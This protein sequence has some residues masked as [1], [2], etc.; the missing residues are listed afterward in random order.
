MALSVLVFLSPFIESFFDIGFNGLVPWGDHYLK[1]TI[2]T[3]A[4]FQ[5]FL[6]SLLFLLTCIGFRVHKTVWFLSLTIVL[7]VLIIFIMIL[8]H[9][10]FSIAERLM[11]VGPELILLL[12]IFFLRK[13]QKT[14][15]IIAVLLSSI[16]L[17]GAFG[18]LGV[19]LRD[20]L[21]LHKYVYVKWKK[22]G[23]PHEYVL[24][25]YDPSY[26]NPNF[27][28]TDEIMGI[29]IA[30]DEIDMPNEKGWFNVSN[31]TWLAYNE[32]GEIINEYEVRDHQVLGWPDGLDDHLADENPFEDKLGLQESSE[33]TKNWPGGPEALTPAI[34]R[35]FYATLFSENNSTI[36]EENDGI[37]IGDQ[38]FYTSYY[39]AYG[40]LTSLWL[41]ET[42][43][44]FFNKCA[45]STKDMN[46]DAQSLAE[47]FVGMPLVDQQLKDSLGVDFNCYNKEAVSWLFANMVP[48]PGSELTG[49]SFQQLYDALARRH[50][51]LMLAS[52]LKLKKR[53]LLIEVKR[54]N[55]QVVRQ[56]YDARTY[57]NEHY[58]GVLPEFELEGDV[59]EY[60]YLSP[61][62]AIGYW[63]RRLIDGSANT[64]LMGYEH[65]LREY[66]NSWYLE[67]REEHRLHLD[68]FRQS[69]YL[70]AAEIINYGRRTEQAYEPED[71][72][73]L[74]GSIISIEYGDEEIEPV[75]GDAIKSR[76]E[77]WYPGKWVRIPEI[78]V[79]DSYYYFPS[80][81]KA[82]DLRFFTYIVI[83][84]YSEY[85]FA[86]VYHGQYIYEEPV[87]LY[88][89]KEIPD[90]DE[91]IT[92]TSSIK[93]FEDGDVEIHSLQKVNGMLKEEFKHIIGKD[94]VFESY[95]QLY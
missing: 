94:E 80:L 72:T 6:A 47:A 76:M 85:Q 25:F 59:Y 54:F 58:D 29:M 86:V 87:L 56:G 17:V 46:P 90:T 22:K 34:R 93:Q 11:M 18:V 50:V 23:N 60:S 57:L 8:L 24:Q 65:I 95:E 33:E 13:K 55:D 44:K 4:F 36:W 5:F 63:L 84:S 3:L 12:V 77:S 81:Y 32:D 21:M 67:Y 15:F 79:S 51:R 42:F 14:S 53:G 38:Q 82:G 74:G 73:H 68:D 1:I 39:G 92:Y 71:Y 48:Y 88:A 27:Y 91:V 31:G 66:D 52:Y 2:T 28:I 35:D 64:L 62:V 40:L 70:A 9:G 26:Y 20:G 41:R 37:Q 30:N 49:T 61:K 10:S 19:H 83:S 89:R 45:A 43:K 75:L 69:P 78:D 7:G 16:A